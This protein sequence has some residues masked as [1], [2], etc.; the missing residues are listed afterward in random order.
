MRSMNTRPFLALVVSA[1]SLLLAA[2][3]T[4][5]ST[6]SVASPSTPLAA[7]TADHTSAG[8]DLLSGSFGHEAVGASQVILSKNDKAR[9][10]DYDYRSYV[11]WKSSQKSE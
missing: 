9:Q 1:A 11:I 5:G 6:S 7:V 4:T 3:G 2:C 10:A 8:G